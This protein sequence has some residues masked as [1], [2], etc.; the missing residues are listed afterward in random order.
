M[1]TSTTP[2]TVGLRR[3]AEGITCD[4]AAVELLIAFNGGTLLNGPWIRRSNHGGYWFDAETAAAEGALSGGENRVLRVAMSL[5][6]SDHPA[7]LGDVLT[8]IDPTAFS[9]IIQAMGRAFGFDA[10]AATP[11]TAEL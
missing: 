5:V 11:E 1:N 8:G 10:V 9:L 7:D 4:S 6:S 2:L 3:W